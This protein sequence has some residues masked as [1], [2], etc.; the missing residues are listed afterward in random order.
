VEV[1]E[2]DFHEWDLIQMLVYFKNGARPSSAAAMQQD[3][4]FLAILSVSMI[5][6]LLRPK[7]GAL[8]FDF[9]N[10]Y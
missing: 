1:N 8:R 5:S 6:T 4:W 9:E 10:A 2:G 3:R 7:T